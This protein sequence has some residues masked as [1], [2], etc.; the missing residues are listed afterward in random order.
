MVKKDYFVLFSIMLAMLVVFSLYFVLATHTVG[1]SI[2]GT[3][4][5][6]KEDIGFFYNISIANNDSTQAANITEV[7]ITLNSNFN[8]I[9]NSNGSSAFA[10]GM[11]YSNLLLNWVNNS[12]N[13]YVING[14]NSTRY[15]WFNASVAT[16]GNYNIAV[17]LTNG[18]GAYSYNVSVAVNDTTAPVVTQ[19][20]PTDTSSSVSID[21]TFTF[22]V[23]DDSNVSNCSLFLD[24]A[25][26]NVLFNASTSSAN[27]MTNTS[28]SIA[29][30]IWSV[31]CTDS[32]GNTGASSTW[33]FT[34]NDGSANSG[35]GGT[36][37]SEWTKTI[38]VNDDQF[39]V[40]YNNLFSVKN[41]A[42]VSVSGVSHYIG[43]IGL[44]DTQA[45]INVSSIPQ[46]AV[47][48]IGD[49]KKFDV[50]GDS[51]YDLVVV[52]NSIVSSSANITISPISGEAVSS[53]IENTNTNL[54][55]T[56]QESGNGSNA[57]GNDGLDN[58]E[59][60]SNSLVI[61]IVVIFVVILLI[62][63]GRYGLAR[64]NKNKYY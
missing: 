35:T 14:S 48:N 46:Q 41:R 53:E 37:G 5:S 52:L 17:T 39:A 24:G 58:V 19:I 27:G 16:P 21:Y 8:F 56:G 18:T 30:H 40:G 11:N 31:N 25:L 23:S 44:T 47:F 29:P 49:E 55:Q 64:R 61:W 32:V 4:Y 54:N 45:T 33:G 6:V 26:V 57:S 1:I 9:A 51:Y 38:S 34:V 50:N 10:D 62:I 22:I 2:G 13:G 36:T 60:S 42:R 59:K 15:F 12:N 3:A 63:G 7:N 20:S 43:V 28:L